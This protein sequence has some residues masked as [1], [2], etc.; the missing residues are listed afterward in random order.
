MGRSGNLHQTNPG[1]G[2]AADGLSAMSALVCRAGSLLCAFPLEHVLE[3]M[4][5]LPLEALAGVPPFILGLCVVRGAPIPAVDVGKL[6]GAHQTPLE[7]IVTVRVG[8]GVVALVVERVIG[9]QT[10]RSDETVDL[11]PLLRDAAADTVSAIGALD[12]ELL[13]FLNVARSIPDAVFDL[14]LPP[15]VDEA[16]P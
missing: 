6:I 12:S 3:I 2:A 15:P 9:V 4:R 11:P 14:R 16:T 8:S 10:F 1:G 7:W 5:C 13:L